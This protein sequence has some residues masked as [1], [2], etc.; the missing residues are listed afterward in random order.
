MDPILIKRFLKY[1]KSLVAVIGVTLLVVVFLLIIAVLKYLEMVSANE[2]IKRMRDTISDLQDARKN[3]VAVIPGNLDLL[4][5]DY[6]FYSEKNKDLRPY[7]G[8]PYRKALDAMAKV[9]NWRDGDEV[10]QK[11]YDF[12]AANPR[13]RMYD[14]YKR[15]RMQH[16]QRWEN[17]IDVFA[18]QAQAVS[19]ETINAGNVDDIFLQAIGLPREMSGRS[20]EYCQQLIKDIEIKLN[21]TVLDK[22]VDVNKDAADFS[23]FSTG[24]T[25]PEKIAESM[26]NMEIVG[27]MIS[28]IVKNVPSDRKIRYMRALDCVKYN[29]KVRYSEDEKID[30]YKYNIKFIGTMASLRKVIAELNSAINDSRIYVLRNLK[31]NVPQQDDQA[32]VVI[33]L[34]E[35]PV[36]LDK[37]GKKIEIIF[38]SDAH[39]PYNQ[40]R[41]YGKVLIGSDPFFVIEMDLDYMILKQHEYQR[42]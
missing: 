10:A 17:A 34:V 19:F 29:G 15:F 23:L 42:R 22:N 25:T 2:E 3:K 26:Q 5:K 35:A 36:L 11:F 13:E 4:K 24:L 9:M 28:R 20:L 7:F 33:G 41:D 40:R 31:L 38:K 16:G 27:D 30:V 32:A 39:L 37:D 12:L 21:K 8:H 14:R 18:K 1:N 6:Q